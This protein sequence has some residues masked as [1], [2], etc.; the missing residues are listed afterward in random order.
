MQ[1][2]GSWDVATLLGEEPGF[3]TGGDLGWA[4]FPTV[5]GGNGNPADLVG[6]T[7]VYLSVSA[8]ASAAQRQTAISY[9]A[10]ELTTTSYVK[11]EI[12][13]GEV[14]V[15]NGASKY[16]AG[17][18]ESDFLNY[19]FNAAQQAPHFQYSWDQALGSA[20]EQPLYTNLGEVFNLTETPQKFAAALNRA[21]Q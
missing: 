5:S 16:F 1:L 13:A 19:T 6:N 2:M 4:S 7:S 15:V 17:A 14:P 21:D 18:P 3:V 9:L 20:K 11:A 8:K 12:K 10:K